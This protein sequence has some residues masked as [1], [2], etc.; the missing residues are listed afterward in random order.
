MAPILEI[1]E[2]WSTP[3]L[4]LLPAPLWPGIDVD[5]LK[6]FIF[7]KTEIKKNGEIHQAFCL[8]VAQDHMNGA[9][10]ETKTVNISW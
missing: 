6:I 8:N 3:S 9:P 4:P 10:N 5:P 7:E 2:V 1:C